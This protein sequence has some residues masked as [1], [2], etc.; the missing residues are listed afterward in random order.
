MKCEPTTEG[1]RGNSASQKRNCFVGRLAKWRASQHLRLPAVFAASACLVALGIAQT[2]ESPHLYSVRNIDQGSEKFIRIYETVASFL[3]EKQND[4][5]IP[6]KIKVIQHLGNLLYLVQDESGAI[7]AVQ[8]LPANIADGETFTGVFQDTG[9]LHQYVSVL[10]AN[11]QVR[12]YKLAEPPAK[13]TM[14][15]FIRRLKAGE[16]FVVPIGTYQV[17]CPRCNGFGEAT[18]LRPA[19]SNCLGENYFTYPQYFSIQW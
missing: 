6:I 13:I 9:R 4:K 3:V 15:D 7:S 12:V 10:G 8:G 14:D 16:N 11:K 19:C 1:S 5:R 18:G 2:E 17:R